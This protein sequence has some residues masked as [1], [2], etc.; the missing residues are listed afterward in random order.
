M[1]LFVLGA[2]GHTGSH[3][4]DIALSRSHDVTAFAR[5][6]EKIAVRNPRLTVVR[7]NPLD[8]NQLTDA[9]GGHDAI[10]SAIGVRPPQAFRPHSTVQECAAST[11]AAMTRAQVTR[12][13]FVSAAVLF[14]MK[15]LSYAFF[16]WLL[17]H[18][19]R[20]LGTAEDIVRATT[21]DWTIVRPPRLTNGNNS[22]YRTMR[23]ALPHNGNV[24]TFR[25]V[26]TFMTDTVEQRT[27]IRELVG[28]A[29]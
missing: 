13:V 10:L 16:R 8:V 7:G 26:A 22:T 1:K 2:T 27:H 3:I 17:Q 19:S 25:S 24:A 23:D 20:D 29:R 28:L 4:I 14:P 11:M 21:F 12:F 18:I 5:S 9:L 6:P 15:G